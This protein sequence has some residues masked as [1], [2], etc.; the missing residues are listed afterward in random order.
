MSMTTAPCWRTLRLA[1]AFLLAAGC[2]QILGN[3]RLE[4]APDEA[5]GADSGVVAEGL[6]AG[7]GQHPCTLDGMCPSV[8]D[9]PDAAPVKC[10]LPTAAACSESAC[11]AGS[12]AACLELASMYDEHTKVPGVAKDDA[13]A[14]PL[15]QRACSAGEMTACNRLGWF[16]NNA[17]G[18]P[19]DL[20]RAKDLYTQAC[21]A[22]LMAACD[23]LGWMLR[24]DTAAPNVARALKL[25]K[26]ACDANVAS[27]CNNLGFM[28][29]EGRGID[30]DLP[31]ALVYLKRACD[32]EC[33]LGCRAVAG[34]YEQ[35]VAPVIPVDRT[36]AQLYSDR[37]NMGIAAD[38]C[39]PAAPLL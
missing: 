22:G 14:A 32:G 19:L 4:A 29:R 12:G 35:G 33:I 17:H 21:D 1:A 36:Q 28:Y 13:K 39:D 2:N 30:I 38:T 10:T 25:F 15:Y 8:P 34:I 7:P 24:A 26:D 9:M 6:D 27:A 16:H 18:V 31:S 3:E 20:A 23:N 37:A 5:P 11:E